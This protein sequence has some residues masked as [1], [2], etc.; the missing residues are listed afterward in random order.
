MLKIQ[1]L[2]NGQTEWKE[3]SKKIPGAIKSKNVTTIAENFEYKERDENQIIPT[4]DD[5]LE[6]I[7]T[8]LTGMYM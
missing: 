8:D 6:F 1:S 5:F 3:K 4:L 7:L 2:K